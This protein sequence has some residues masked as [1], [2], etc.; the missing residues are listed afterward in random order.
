MGKLVVL[1]EAAVFGLIGR[2]DG[3]VGVVEEPVT[4]DWLPTGQVRTSFLR[5]DRRG[6][7][8]FDQTIDG[9]GDMAGLLLPGRASLVAME[10]P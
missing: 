9:A 1:H 2:H 10:H 5:Y 3:E 4:M 7:A 6:Y 8:Q